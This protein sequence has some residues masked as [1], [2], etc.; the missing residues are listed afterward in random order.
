MHKSIVV[1]YH[2][3]Y[4]DEGSK[5]KELVDISNISN[6]KELDDSL[7]NNWKIESQ[8][9]VSLNPQS[10]NSHNPTNSVV[11]IIYTLRSL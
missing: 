2:V 10:G 9:I 5:Y 1:F 11:C 4:G 7:K 6:K 3:Y 8:E